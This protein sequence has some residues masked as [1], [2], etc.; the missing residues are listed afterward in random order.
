MFDA[1]SLLPP[2]NATFV[3]QSVEK[4]MATRVRDNEEAWKGKPRTSHNIRAEEAAFLRVKLAN[5]E[6]KLRVT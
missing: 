1:Y 5:I 4:T 6:D 2:L 3:P